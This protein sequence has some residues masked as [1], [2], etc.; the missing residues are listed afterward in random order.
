[1]NVPAQRVSG[2]DEA[3]QP[4][5]FWITPPNSAEGGARRLTFLCPCG[6]G[7]LAG[8]KVRDDGAKQEGAW[9]WDRNETAPTTDPSINVMEQKK[10]GAGV[11]LRNP[12]GSPAMESHWHGH[13]VA[14][15]FKPC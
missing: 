6:C 15:V 14:G 2:F 1:M 12:D 9:G 7:T 11:G 4:G 8:I 10:D 13:L 5:D 3:K